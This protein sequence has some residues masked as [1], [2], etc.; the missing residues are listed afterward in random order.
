MKEEGEVEIRYLLWRTAMMFAIRPEPLRK[1]VSD[2]FSNKRRV[3]SH[4]SD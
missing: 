4:V 1:L 2:S 3:S